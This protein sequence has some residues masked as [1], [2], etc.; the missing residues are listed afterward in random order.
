MLHSER[1]VCQQKQRGNC[2][3]ADQGRILTMLQK[4]ETY[5]S[6]KAK[7]K[8]TISW[9]KENSH[10]VAI[11]RDVHTC[12][13]RQRDHCKSADQGRILTILRKCETCVSAN[14]KEQLTISWSTENS[15]HVAK[16]RDVRVSKAKGKLTISWSKENSHHVAK[17][18]DV[19]VSKGKGTSVSHLIKGEFSPCCESERRTCQQRQGTTVNQLIKREFSPCC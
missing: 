14:A 3:L 15:H 17:V 19:R 4:W 10:H 6:A 12:Q 11:V 5:V 18:R 9:S 7:G 13:Q 8:L 1:R 2:Q 16:V